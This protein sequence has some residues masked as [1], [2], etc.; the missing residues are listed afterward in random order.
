MEAL[1]RALYPYTSMGEMK[2]SECSP[3]QLK[4]ELA[5]NPDVVILFKEDRLN[6]NDEVIEQWMTD[7]IAVEISQYVENGGGWVAWHSGLASYPVESSYTNM[8][9]GYFLH[10]PDQHQLVRYTNV[11]ESPIISEPVAFEILDEHYFVHYDAEN[12][13]VFLRSESIDGQAVAGWS[14]DF[15]KGKV[16]CLTPAHNREGLLQP[17][18]LH[19]LGNCVQWAASR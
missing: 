5:L 7:E 11:N 19:I 6:P 17:E 4:D 8:L 18:L 2:L 14:H 16:C 12:T 13:N 1:E 9:R 3:E 15:G 10:H